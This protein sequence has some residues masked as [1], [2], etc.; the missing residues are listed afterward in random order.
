MSLHN[1]KY[2]IQSTRLPNW[3][4]RNEGF[5]FITICTANRINYFGNVIRSQM[6][7]S[8]EGNIVAKEWSKTDQIR[9][10]VKLDEWIIMPNHL[11]M[12]LIISE[13]QI[14]S[15]YKNPSDTH[16]KWASSSVGSIINQFKGRCTKRIRSKG[17]TQFAWQSRFYEHIIRTERSLENIRRYIQSNP[18]NWSEDKYYS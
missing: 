14:E 4:Y 15:S 9:P 16:T 11:H 6:I 5:Y 10:Y 18:A 2:R 1:N 7:L 3:D 17:Q 8:H 12:I 13:K